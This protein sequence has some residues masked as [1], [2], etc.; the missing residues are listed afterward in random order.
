MQPMSTAMD[1]PPRN[2]V[3][4]ALADL[5]RNMLTSPDGKNIQVSLDAICKLMA[6]P[7]LMLRRPIE[8]NVTEGEK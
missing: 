7:P 4:I 2:L 1:W 8:Q 6:N 3:H 5:D